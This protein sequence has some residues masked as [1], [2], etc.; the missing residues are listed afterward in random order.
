MFINIKININ[1]SILIV[2][3][4]NSYVNVRVVIIYIKV[5]YYQSKFRFEFSSIIEIGENFH[6]TQDRVLNMKGRVCA[7]GVEDLRRLIMEE[8]ILLNLYYASR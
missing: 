2:L 4:Y 7:P 3:I 6:I 8:S 5:Q 1:S